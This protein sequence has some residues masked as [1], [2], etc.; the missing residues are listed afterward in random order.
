MRRRKYRQ[1]RSVQS[2]IGATHKRCATSFT[3]S[4]IL[5][6]TPSWPC[7]VELACGYR[8]HDCTLAPSVD[9]AKHALEAKIDDDCQQADD[10]GTLNDIGCVEAGETDD[11]R[12]AETLGAYGRGERRRADVE[13]PR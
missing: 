3:C 10:D 1:C 2:I 12:R 11:D 5:P 8:I 6:L 9:V 7:G 4:L 13:D